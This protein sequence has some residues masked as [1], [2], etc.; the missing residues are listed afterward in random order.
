MPEDMEVDNIP[1]DDETDEKDPSIHCLT[2]NT[3]SSWSNSVVWSADGRIGVLTD[4]CIYILVS[5]QIVILTITEKIFI[6]K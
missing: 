3:G 4:T 5:F 1:N 6:K 2:F